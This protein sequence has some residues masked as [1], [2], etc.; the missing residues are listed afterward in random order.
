MMDVGGL[1]ARNQLIAKTQEYLL[2]HGV[3]NMKLGNLG[4]TSSGAAAA[5]TDEEKKIQE[6]GDIG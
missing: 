4:T 1:E 6:G 2:S 5:F 3:S